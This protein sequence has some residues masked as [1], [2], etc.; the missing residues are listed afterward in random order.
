MTGRCAY[1]VGALK[2]FDSLGVRPRLLFPKFLI[3]LCSDRYECA[4]L[5]V[6]NLKFVAALP[7]SEIIMSI[8]KI[9]QSL[10]TP[11]RPRSP[12]SKILLAFVRIDSANVPAKF[13]VRSFTRS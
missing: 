5:C 2:I 1:Y 6:Q 3:G 12:F 7:V 13:E 8:Q 4:T 10:D 9:G 11:S